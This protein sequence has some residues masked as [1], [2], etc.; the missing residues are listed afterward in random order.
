MQLLQNRMLL[1]SLECCAED[2]FRGAHCLPLIVLEKIDVMFSKNEGRLIQKLLKVNFF[3][4][5]YFSVENI[6]PHSKNVLSK[7][8]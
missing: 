1:K 6:K 5:F 3:T 4:R 7:L 2:S 8:K